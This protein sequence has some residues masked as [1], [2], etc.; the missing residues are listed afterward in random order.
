M[1]F[2]AFVTVVTV[3]L[4]ATASYLFGHASGYRSARAT[5]LPVLIES[6]RDHARVIDELGRLTGRKPDAME[7]ERAW[8]GRL[9]EMGLEVPDE[10]PADG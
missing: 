5:Y 1:S 8:E 9:R 6:E 10:R 4:V 3:L 7:R 2:D